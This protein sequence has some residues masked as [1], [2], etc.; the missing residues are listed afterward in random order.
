MTYLSWGRGMQLRESSYRCAAALLLAS[1]IQTTDILKKLEQMILQTRSIAL[2]TKV[3]KTGTKIH[4]MLL[5]LD[6]T[7]DSRAVILGARTAIFTHH[8]VALLKTSIGER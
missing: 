7:P 8:A 1:F 5:A 6:H 3:S 4:Q 2:E